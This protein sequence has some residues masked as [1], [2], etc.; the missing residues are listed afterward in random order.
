MKKISQLHLEPVAKYSQPRKAPD[1]DPGSTC[2]CGKTQRG[3]SEFESQ[4]MIYKLTQIRIP[5][6][7][8][9]SSQCAPDTVVMATSS[10]RQSALH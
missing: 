3:F 7:Q 6:L 2:R 9:I 5:L 8:V 10:I 4:A 1:L